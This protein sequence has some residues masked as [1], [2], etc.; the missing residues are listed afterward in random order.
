MKNGKFAKTIFYFLRAY[1]Y[2]NCDITVI[3]EAVIVTVAVYF[4]LPFFSLIHPTIRSFEVWRIKFF[5]KK[6]HF[7]FNH[8]T[9]DWHILTPLQ[10]QPF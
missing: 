2:G 1:P 9:I 10:T 4:S 3:G 7:F 8:C 6:Q 5:S